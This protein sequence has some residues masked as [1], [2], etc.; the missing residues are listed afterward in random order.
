MGVH[1]FIF[2]ISLKYLHN[3]NFLCR[4]GLDIYL[5]NNFDPMST[6]LSDM[7]V[8]RE[9]VSQFQMSQSLKE[10]QT[11]AM[12]ASTIHRMKQLLHTQEIMQQGQT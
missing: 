8:F 5:G 12:C 1:A 10:C 9:C 3:F 6:A 11:G 4:I 7:C 2:T